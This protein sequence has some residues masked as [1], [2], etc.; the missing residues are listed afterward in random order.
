MNHHASG[1]RWHMLVGALDEPVSG[2]MYWA[3]P[4]V[5]LP[6]QAPG[7]PAL[8]GTASHAIGD[9]VAKELPEPEPQTEAEWEALPIGRQ[10]GHWLRR[11]GLPTVSE[12]ALVYDAATDTARRIEGKGHRDY[13][14]LL[15]TEIPTTLDYVWVRDDRVDVIDLKTGKRQNAHVE[16]LNIQGLAAARFFSRPLAS[17]AFAFARKTKC[18]A[19]PW[20]DMNADRLEAEAWRASAVVRRLPVAQPNVG[21]WCWQCPLGKSQCPAHATTDWS[22]DTRVLADDVPLF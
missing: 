16:Q 21:R 22:E 17:I 1:S 2:C 14:D 5:E 7:R 12:I 3:R 20:A 9:A 18:D 4:D 11:V 8:V 19:D 13:G 10:V 15:P 6:P